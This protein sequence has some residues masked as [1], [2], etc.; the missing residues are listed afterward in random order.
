MGLG[1]LCITQEFESQVESV[2]C[3]MSRTYSTCINC[4]GVIINLQPLTHK[5]ALPCVLVAAQADQ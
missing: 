2:L 5:W 3:Q 4:M 1:M